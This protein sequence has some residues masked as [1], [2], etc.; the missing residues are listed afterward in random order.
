MSLV[1]RSLADWLQWQ[2]SLHVSA[3]DLGLERIRTVAQ[4][5]NLLKPSFPIITVAGTNGKGSTVAMLTS[6]LKAAGYQVGTY[7]SPH[8]LRY[9]ERIALN[10]EPVTD[11]LLCAA[12]TAIETVRGETSLTYFEFGTLA[13]LWLFHQQ[14][15]DV[16][17]LEVGLGG[18]LDATNA[19]DCDIA[20]VTS[21]DI[22]HVDWLGDNREAIGYEKASIGR[23]GR[24]LICGDTQPPHS[25]A[26]T[27]QSIGAQLWQNGVDFQVI[28]QP[29]TKTFSIQFAT[30]KLS[31]A[32]LT[33]L[34]YPQLQGEFQLN[35]AACALVALF[36]LQN[37]LTQLNRAIFGQ[38][39]TQVKLAGRLQQLQKQPEVWIDVAHNPQAARALADWL[40]QRPSVGKTWV[41]FSLLIDKNLA[42]VVEV[43]RGQVDEWHVFAVDSPRATPLATLVSGIQQ[44]GISAVIAHDAIQTAWNYVQARLAAQDRVVIFGSFL[45]VSGALDEIFTVGR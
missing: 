24:P 14:T 3:I 25:I 16:A 36:L 28:A 10:A 41:I 23:A 34:P 7:T 31:S 21:I 32:S 8:L 12:F 38:G 17:V 15:V 43:L 1:E 29:T 6:I 19:W 42:E 45:V 18:R 11:E 27:A 44:Q 30:D 26:T 35:N 13:A 40:A 37:R 2:E 39:L 9:N 22:D 4:R 20:I 5:L 33:D